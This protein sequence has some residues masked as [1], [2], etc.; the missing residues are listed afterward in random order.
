MMQSGKIYI[1]DFYSYVYSLVVTLNSSIMFPSMDTTGNNLILQDGTAN[2]RDLEE[3]HREDME[4]LR[5]IIEADHQAYK[6][7]AEGQICKLHS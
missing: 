2:Y 7:A 1:F 5:L 6:T 4:K 3:D